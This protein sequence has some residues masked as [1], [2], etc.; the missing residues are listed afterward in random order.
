MSEHPSFDRAKGFVALP[1]EV[2]E[3]DLTPGAFRL[4]VEL[5]RMANADGFCWPSLDQL[6]TRM[7][8]SR[9][10]I[11]GYVK[12]LRDAG[13]VKTETQ[14]TANGYNYRLK[15]RV[16]FWQ[17]WRASLSG[18]TTKKAER[19]VQPVERLE[20]TQK[21]RHIN[22]DTA[23]ADDDI[24]YVLKKWARCF[25][26][27]PYPLTA[28]QPSLGLLAAT[29]KILK[30]PKPVV[31]ISADIEEQLAELWSTLNV[32]V[33][34]GELNK[35]TALIER[36]ALSTNEFRAILAS[37]KQ[38]WKRHWR[39]SPTIDQFGKMVEKAKGNTKTQQ[40]VLLKSYQ[41]RW[42]MAENSLRPGPDFGSVTSNER[43]AA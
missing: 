39:Q 7:G 40:F 33:P 6:S 41:K 32:K 34:I 2:L 29:E 30:S 36:K 25:K 26:G 20:K 11:S 27:A 17:D 9:A 43:S 31:V 14:K 4:L 3:I 42:E 24:A 28:Q 8:R 1:V 22:Q 10:A 12:A 21:Q 38:Q 15:Y 19:S 37:V 13:L 35:H 16:T 23:K 5:C 18:A